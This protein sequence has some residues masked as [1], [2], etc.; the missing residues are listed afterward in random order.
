MFPQLTS[1]Q[2]FSYTTFPSHSCKETQTNKGLKFNPLWLTG[3]IDGEGCFHISIYKNNNKIGWA[4]KLIFEIRL[5]VR[6]KVLLEKI[7]NYFQAG[8]LF[9][10]S[11]DGISFR[12][13]STKDLAKLIAHLDKYPLKTQKFSDYILFKEV[14][15]LI[16]NKEHLTISGLHKIVAIKA[17]MNLG[18][19]ESLQAAFT[20]IIPISRPVVNNL[21]IEP[22]WFAGFASAEG[23]FFVNIFNSLT[24][25]LKVGVQLEFSLSQHKRDE[26]LMKGLI[27]FLKCG[28]VHSHNNACYYRIGNLLGITENIIP[29]FKNYPILGEKA[30]DFSD[31]CEVAEMIKVKKHLTE[32]GLT[33]IRKLKA[34]M[35]T[36][37][38]KSTGC[39]GLEK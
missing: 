6:D 21:P 19:S 31:F 18:L 29:L 2:K 23:C 11:N 30:K 3:F 32:E 34:G 7:Q 36:G 16:L 5:H 9:I 24:H 28:N 33:Q 26:L 15:N 14:F 1:L 20:N 8:N 13:Q 35:N 37:R 12:I 10:T 17:S 4:V 25:K 39:N 27:E 22:E 38:S